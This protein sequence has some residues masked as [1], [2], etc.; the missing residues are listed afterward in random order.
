M[1]SVVDLTYAEGEYVVAYQI[2]KQSYSKAKVIQSISSNDGNET[3][4][5]IHYLVSLNSFKFRNLMD[6][7][8]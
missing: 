7:I 3:K 1:D 4:Y 5:R 8:I 6:Y 2:K